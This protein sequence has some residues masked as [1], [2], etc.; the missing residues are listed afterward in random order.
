VVAGLAAGE[1]VVA[2]AGAGVLPGQRVRAI[3]EASGGS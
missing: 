1:S 2:A 3:S